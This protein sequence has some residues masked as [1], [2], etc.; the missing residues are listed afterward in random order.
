MS[1]QDNEI[2]LILSNLPPE[3]A[4]II[5][6]TLIE[7]RKAACVNLSPIR[8][9][10]RWKDEICVDEEVTL[11]AKVSKAHSMTCIHQ[12]K[13]LHPYELPEIIVLPVDTKHSYGPYLEWV[14]QETEE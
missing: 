3:S 5:A 1:D 13:A 12:I 6:K 9:V 2:V 10:Y 11:L 4:E 8:S 14:T 7:E